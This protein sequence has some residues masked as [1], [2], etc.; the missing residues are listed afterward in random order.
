MYPGIHS[1]LAGSH[2]HTGKM[3]CGSKAAS[4]AGGALETSIIIVLV[5]TDYIYIAVNHTDT[6]PVLVY[7]ELPGHG[8]HFMVWRVVLITIREH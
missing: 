7:L 3:G 2:L 4:P 6:Q 5:C 8:H 1:G